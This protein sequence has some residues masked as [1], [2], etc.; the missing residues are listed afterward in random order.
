M[1]IG[2]FTLAVIPI[3][4]LGAINLGLCVVSVAASMLR[5]PFQL[6]TNALH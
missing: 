1:D 2:N 5:I 4:L 6:L 3:L